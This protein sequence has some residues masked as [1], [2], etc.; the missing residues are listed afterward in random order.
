V[1]S[2]DDRIESPVQD[3]NPCQS[4]KV[5]HQLHGVLSYDDHPAKKA[6]I[7]AAPGSFLARLLNLS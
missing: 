6:R 3:Q 2:L 7:G 1:E 5:S 4:S